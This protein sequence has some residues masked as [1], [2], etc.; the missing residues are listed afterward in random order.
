MFKQCKKCNEVKD[1]SQFHK[2]YGK[3]IAQCNICRNSL[4]RQYYCSNKLN[5]NEHHKQF[6]KQNKGKRNAIWAKRKAAKLQRTP[7]W[8]TEQQLSEIR[9]LYET[10]PKG[11][12]VDH[13]V[14]LQGKNVSGLHVPWNL[15]VIPAKDNIKKSNKF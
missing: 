12:H 7:K 9:K 8:L 6:Y 11:Y 14:P 13:I 1:L 5:I 15:Q 10:C 3:P 4:N 2:K